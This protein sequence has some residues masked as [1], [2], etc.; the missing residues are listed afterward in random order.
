MSSVPRIVAPGLVRSSSS[1]PVFQSHSRTRRES[2]R[3]RASSVRVHQ[4]SAH[5]Y[6]PHQRRQRNAPEKC[7]GPGEPRM[8]QC[9]HTPDSVAG[10]NRRKLSGRLRRAGAPDRSAADRALCA[11]EGRWPAV[12]P[13]GPERLRSKAILPRIN[14]GRRCALSAT[15][16]AWRAR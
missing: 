15:A 8:V 1:S 12:R 3:S 14:L 9:L 4:P 5:R 16:S 6:L 2:A 11:P 7:D 10:Q 13:G